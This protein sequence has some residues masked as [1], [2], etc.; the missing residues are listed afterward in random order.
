M[1][2]GID[3]RYLSHGLMG[4]VHRYITYL[5][6]AL[7]RIAPQHSFF[8]YA[9]D[10]NPFEFPDLPENATLRILDYKNGLSSV[11]HDFTMRKWM[12]QDKVDVA[13][14]PANYGFG[15]RNART[16]ITLHD[17]IN[18]LPL[19]EIIR[20]HRK[21]LRS[22]V[23]MTYLHFCSTTAVN[24]AHLLVTVS[25]YSKTKILDNSHI[26]PDRV[27]VAPS[28][29]APTMHRVEDAA[30]REDVRQ[31]HSLLKPFVLAD[32][33]KNPGVLVKAWALLP[34]AL[35]ENTQIVFFSR[36]PTPPPVVTEAEAAGYARLLVRPS[37]EDLMTL[38]SMA[39]AFIFPS[40]IEGFGLPL[41]EAMTCGTPVIASD[42]G[43]IPEVAGNA[44][45]L[46]DADDADTLAHHIQQ[47]L[48]SPAETER[49][50]QLG[51]IRAAQFS[52]DNTA[53]KVLTCY[54]RSLDLQDAIAAS[55]SFSSSSTV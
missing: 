2:I 45:L 49:L 22:M 8:L 42:R 36:T 23:M 16:I 35:R 37:N 33:L 24:R 9:D 32:A 40:W 14:F 6:P 11:Y 53:H 27:V 30:L 55:K 25:N 44:A 21:Q 15:P 13:H 19:R 34:E 12:A 52:W 50:R 5:V 31:R 20:G 10:K 54:E 43:S 29:P 48:T 26:A 17:E 39:E 28:G 46:S 18:I 4:G 7:M 51:Y 38:Y 3:V 41:L 1:R 47:V